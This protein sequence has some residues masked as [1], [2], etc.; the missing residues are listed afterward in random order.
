[1]QTIPKI[2]SGG[3]KT[4]LGSCYVSL[5]LLL[6]AAVALAGQS[7]TFTAMVA[8]ADET[9]ATVAWYLKGGYW[10]EDIQHFLAHPDSALLPPSRAK[11][12]NGKAEDFTP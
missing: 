7:Q 2:S 10:R 4:F 9:L 8:E 12:S 6:A 1:M 5:G 11:I 3:R